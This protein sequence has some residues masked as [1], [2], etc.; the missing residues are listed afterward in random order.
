LTRSLFERARQEKQ[1]AKE[2]RTRFWTVV[3][4]SFTAGAATVGAVVGVLKA[5]GVL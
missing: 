3:A 2:N 4:G 1:V 5:F